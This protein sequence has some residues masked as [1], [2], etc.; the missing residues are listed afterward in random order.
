MAETRA[1]LAGEAYAVYGSASLGGAR[2]LSDSLEQIL[3]YGK[4]GSCNP[5]C[6]EL[7]LPVATGD[8]N[9]DGISDLIAADWSA[10]SFNGTR[11][12]AGEAYV[13][14]GRCDTDE[15]GQCDS[16]D[17]DDDGDGYLDSRELIHSS[18]PLH[19]QSGPELCDGVDTDKDGVVDELVPQTNWDAD[20]DGVR[21]CLDSSVDSDGDTQVNTA[22]TDD[23][24]DTF[25]DAAEVFMG[26]DTLDKCPDAAIDDAWPLDQ[27]NNRFANVVDVI[28]FRGKTPT[29]LGAPN[30][31]RRLD[32][33]AN[34]FINV[35]D[36]L[37]YRG[38]VPSGCSG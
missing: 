37:L 23:D 36:V 11:V 16:V 28:R 15:D 22:D 12:A 13:I 26:T 34:S 1:T 35:S 14:L 18:D 29:S 33:D 6:P 25:V 19:P 3:M 24:G 21:D 31:D 5:N 32:F 20:G 10:N 2:Q 8:T 9:G 38:K 4:V 27:D 17:L 30:Y 7:G